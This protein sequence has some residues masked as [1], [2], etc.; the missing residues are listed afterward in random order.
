M[1]LALHQPQS[2]ASLVVVDIAP[3]AAHSDLKAFRG[4]MDD[5]RRILARRIQSRKEA[6]AVLAETVDVRT[7]AHKK[8]GARARARAHEKAV[9]RAGGV[10]DGAV[11]AASLA[12]F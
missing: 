7:T 2:V 9:A 11:I 6:D 12:Q 3:V 10:R 4:Y 1:T 8:A 5:M